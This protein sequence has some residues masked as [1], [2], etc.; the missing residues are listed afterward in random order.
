[1]I[2]SSPAGKR[3]RSSAAAFGPESI[4][5]V[6]AERTDVVGVAGTGHGDDERAGVPGQGDRHAADTA[7]S[8][9][10]GDDGFG[11]HSRRVDQ[12]DGLAA[13]RGQRGSQRRR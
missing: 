5:F 9:D 2:A 8:A 12:G 10:D 1:M 6:S 4:D 11:L 7:S 3:S 13:D